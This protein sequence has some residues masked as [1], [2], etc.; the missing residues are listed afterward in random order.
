M[1]LELCLRHHEKIDGTGYPDGLAGEAL[2]LAARMGAI[3]DVY[4]AVTSNRPYKDAWTPCEALTRMSQ[5]AGHFD[6]VLLDRFADSLGIFPAGTLVRLSTGELGVVIGSADD[7]PENVVVRAFF[8][9]ETLA[10]ITPVDRTIAPAM[11]HPRIVARDSPTFW[12]FADWDAL[13]VRIMS[14]AAAPAAAQGD[15]HPIGPRGADR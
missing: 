14:G 6:P 3:C 10:E 7:A 15:T 2:S 9:C 1:A 11:E 8:D 12:R 4:D 5:W 13:R